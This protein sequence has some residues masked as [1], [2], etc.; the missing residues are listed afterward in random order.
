MESQPLKPLAGVVFP[1]TTVSLTT[2]GTIE[3]GRPGEH[4]TLIVIYRGKHC[5][6]CKKYLNTLQSMQADW[7]HA[8]FDI[9]TLSA[10]SLARAQ[11]DIEQFGWDFP[12]GYNLSETDMRRLGLYIS[13]PLDDNEAQGRFAEPAIFV[14]RPD[15]T[16]QIVAISNGPAARPALDELLDGMIFTKN[17]NKPPRGMVR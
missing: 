13:D 17:N 3:L 10:D 4:W 1:A 6:R 8:G 14:L 7:K 16:I 12:V 9:V 5:G 15:A 2:G 11:D